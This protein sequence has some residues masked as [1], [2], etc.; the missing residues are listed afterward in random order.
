ME[1]WASLISSQFPFFVLPEHPLFLLCGFLALFYFLNGLPFP[2]RFSS[3]VQDSAPKALPLRHLWSLQLE[4]IA[5]SLNSSCFDW[6]TGKFLLCDGHSC[7]AT[8]VMILITMYCHV[9]LIIFKDL[10]I[11]IWKPEYQWG[12]NREGEKSFLLLVCFPMTV[13]AKFGLSW[14]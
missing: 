2:S 1:P 7:A 9:I 4:A 10:F 13:A 3:I 5:V 6:M 8:L 14:G 11:Y 12:R